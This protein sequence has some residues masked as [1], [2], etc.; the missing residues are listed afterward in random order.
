MSK[1]VVV[2][3]ALAMFSIGVHLFKPDDFS[4]FHTPARGRSFFDLMLGAEDVCVEGAVLNAKFYI[5]INVRMT[6]ATT[7]GMGMLWDDVPM[8]NVYLRVLQRAIRRFHRARMQ[9]RLLAVAMAL[10]PRLGECSL[11]AKLESDMLSVV[12]SL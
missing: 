3:P 11:L 7:L 5:S 10:H 2:Y 8:C 4:F 1:Q 6:N 9:A 12:M